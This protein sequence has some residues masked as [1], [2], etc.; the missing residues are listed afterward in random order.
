MPDSPHDRRRL[1]NRPNRP[2]AG[3][4]LDPTLTR[5]GALA[6][7]GSLFLGF[8]ALFF[9]AYVFD[10]A[11]LQSWL[12]GLFNALDAR[13]RSHNN[14]VSAFVI[15]ALPYVAV[16]LGAFLLIVAL[17][18]LGRLAQKVRKRRRL[19][20]REPVSLHEFAE[21]AAAHGISTKVARE[22]Y[23]ELRPHYGKEMRVKLS[24]RMIATLSLKP[25]EIS[26][27][28]ENLLRQTDR[29]R[30]AGDDGGE[31]DSVL[32][33]LACV[34]KSRFRSLSHS[35]LH[36]RREQPAAARR[37]GVTTGHRIKESL[38]R[39][40][41]RQAAKTEAKAPAVARGTSFLKPLRL[42][43]KELELKPKAAPRNEDAG[44][45]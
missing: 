20:N 22:A 26:D 40:A 30:T 1:P 21:A 19:G 37:G 4:S 5:K 44:L 41:A 43:V 27:L 28:Y 18:M 6:H 35:K 13:A 24:D 33:L 16:G 15:A 7:P 17:M 36:L 3:Q 23:R 31:I 9:F 42:P 8:A 39:S 12:D 32:D 2:H 25:I 14:Q 29:Q 10:L 34:E 38:L 45:E 11:G